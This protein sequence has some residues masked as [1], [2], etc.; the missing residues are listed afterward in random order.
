MSSLTQLLISLGSTDPSERVPAEAIINEEKEKN[1]ANFIIAVLTEFRDET[2]PP[3]ARNMAGTLLKNAVAPSLREVAARRQLETKWKELPAP[4]RSQVKNEVLATLGSP[5]RDVRAVAANIVG[6]LSRIELPAGEWPDLTSI[7]VSAAG[8]ESEQYQE[9]ALTAIGYVCEEGRDHEEVEEALRPSTTAILNAIVRCMSSPNEEVMFSATRALCNAMEY[10]HETMEQPEQ[11]AFIVDALCTIAQNCSNLRTREFAMESLVKVAELYYSTLPDYINRLHAITS[12]MIMQSEESVGLLAL[13]F[14]ISI[15][16]TEHMM[17]EEGHQDRCLNYAKSGM[18]FLVDTCLT[19]LVMQV[20]GQEEDDWNRSIAGGKLLQSLAE[21]VGSPIHAPVMSFVYANIESTNWRQK[22]AALMAFGCILGIDDPAAQDAI[23]DTVAQAVNGLLQYIRDPHPMVANTCAWV[24]S[25]VCENFSDVFLQQTSQLTQ[26]LNV[27]G[28]MIRGDDEAMAKRSCHILNNLALAYEDEEHQNTNELSPFFGDIVQVLLYAVDNG[29]SPELRSMANEALN[30]MA[31]AAAND[32]LHIL[33]QLVPAILERLSKQVNIMQMAAQSNAQASEEVEDMAALMCGAIS[34]FAR[35][36]DNSFADYID[37]T[38]Q[39][40][41]QIFSIQKDYVHQEALVAMGSV[42]YA[43]KERMGQYLPGVVPY[44]LTCLKN[45]DEPDTVGSV[46]A[47]IGDLSLACSNAMQPYAA[48]IVNILY[49]NLGDPTVDRDLKCSFLS[50][51]R[52]VILKVLHD[53]GFVP[54]MEPTMNLVHQMFL[55]SCTIDIRGD[56]DGEEYVMTLWEAIGGLYSS[57][58]QSFQGATASA[59]G[60]YLGSMLEFALQVS[61]KCLEYPDTVLA[62]VLVIGDMASVLREA[63]PD[64]RQ[65]AKQA[66][67]TQ[68]VSEALDRAQRLCVG[69]ELKQIK[70]IRTQLQHLQ[71]S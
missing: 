51:F 32:V 47:A 57:I 2:K 5:S 42:A 44:V 12:A 10:I 20:E 58:I 4:I 23:Q 68:A 18:A 70:W 14:W 37:P 40:L 30:S 24:I 48:D 69:D 50:C 6:S 59:L 16:E 56:P 64:L 21:A 63:T 13:Q 29:S 54:Y 31:D 66:L 45:F 22:E 49:A 34:S 1:L 53:Q 28:P 41:V 33:H 35:K 61:I 38:M 27:V 17:M 46:V 7:L 67:L 60:P 39:L 71:R 8:S 19:L 15:C 9:A 52:D 25:I 26:L 3:F 36:L 11:R 43:A 62:A 65:Q 55:A